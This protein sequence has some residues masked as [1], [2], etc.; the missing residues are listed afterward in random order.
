MTEHPFLVQYN[1]NSIRERPAFLQWVSAECPSVVAIQESLENDRIPGRFEWPNGY[2][3]IRK[4]TRY[5]ANGRPLGG[6]VLLVR[7]ESMM[8]E[9]STDGPF[10]AVAARVKIGKRQVTVCSLYWEHGGTV[11]E[12][13]VVAF[14]GSLPQPY[15]VMADVNAKSTSWGSGET[16]ARGMILEGALMSLTSVILNDGNHTRLSPQT[17]HTT[18]PDVTLV[19]NSLALDVDWYVWGDNFGS[20]HFPIVMP[21]LGRGW[22]DTRVTGETVECE[23]RYDWER[24]DWAEY[25]AITGEESGLREIRNMNQL[26]EFVKTCTSQTVPKRSFKMGYETPTPWWSRGLHALR[27]KSRSAARRFRRNNSQENGILYRKTRAIFRRAIKE[28][29]QEHWKRV[30]EDLNFRSNISETWEKLRRIQGKSKPRNRK[31]TLE[32]AGEI[33]DDPEM[34]A[35]ILARKFAEVSSTDPPQITQEPQIEED[36]SHNDPFSFRELEN[37]MR[38]MNK[39]SAPGPDGILY[40]QIKE[41]NQ[42]LLNK[43]LDLF[44]EIWRTGEQ[45]HE[46]KTSIITPVLKP[47][48]DATDPGNYRPIALTSMLARIME[49]M[50]LNR[51]DWIVEKKTCNRQYGFRKHIN[52]EDVI[53]EVS[54]QAQTAKFLCEHTVV[55]CL[56][57]KS[58]YDYTP[59]QLFLNRLTSFGIGGRLWKF[60]DSS[61]TDRRTQVKVQDRRSSY[62]ELKRG[63][64]QGSILSPTL[65]RLALD[66]LFECELLDVKILAYAD[67]ITLISRK[68]GYHDATGC[69]QRTL[70]NVERWMGTNGFGLSADKTKLIHFRDGRSGGEAYVDMKG[71][72]MRKIGVGESSHVN[73][74]GVIF[75]H[76]LNFAEHVRRLGVRIGT[77]LNLMRALL[78]NGFGASQDVLRR[79][80]VATVLPILDYGSIAFNSAPQATLRQL[81][82]IQN[83]A[84]RLISGALKSTPISAM[85]HELAL[86]PLQT[87]RNRI[88][89]SKMIKDKALGNLIPTFRGDIV[90]IE[91]KMGR[92]RNPLRPWHQ[93]SRQLANNTDY[94]FL[95]CSVATL[96]P[97]DHFPWTRRTPDVDLELSGMPKEQTIAVAY[98]KEF[99]RIVGTRYQDRRIIYTDGSRTVSSGNQ[100]NTPHTNSLITVGFAAV[101]PNV[102]T[103]SGRL[104]PQSSIASAELRAIQA[105]LEIASEMTDDTLIAS[106]SLSMLLKIQ[107]TQYTTD[108]ALD[109]LLD[110]LN[111]IQDNNRAVTLIW[112]PSHVGIAGNEMADNL[113]KTTAP[114]IALQDQPVRSNDLKNEMKRITT[115][116]LLEQWS[117]IEWAGNVK[118]T[119][120]RKGYFEGWRRKDQVI[121]S[122]LRMRRT[123]VTHAYRLSPDGSWA[124]PQTQCDCGAVRTVEHM[125]FDCPT[126]DTARR[127]WKVAPQQL[128]SSENEA[129]RLIEFLRET[130]LYSHI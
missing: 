78:G 2:E 118:S 91:Q 93:V 90:R 130:G 63:L 7:E 72:G 16:C 8:R 92:L 39:D 123:N 36:G 65:F 20:D 43:L 52:A 73:I 22:V 64:Q 113:A 50:V 11:T 66:R 77:R 71:Q 49:R 26:V 102:A 60:I 99:N 98:R 103:R 106:D 42:A 32:Q 125:L 120:A 33:V 15:I 100:S 109:N 12:E 9:I 28:A 111:S 5:S 76:G 69:L 59:K 40:D 44:N 25:H 19:S 53:A 10:D 21:L 105:A 129:R 107:N 83:N 94:N 41:A 54:K 47:G 110:T 45:P 27:N 6:S 24:A 70:E 95:R 38:E 85:M 80:Y 88:I 17:G 114:D 82:T 34:V 51:L 62:M 74:L 4:P 119:M 37:A 108:L 89:M 31:I 14:L 97:S 84:M 127:I 126:T 86:L 124:P 104:P 30:V 55:L 81:D 48:R 57:L 79:I 29:I 67:D 1:A 117:C 13:D 115:N 35:E 128:R 87:R 61:T 58:A 121:M 112:I 18:C 46:W 116:E 75:D 3:V 56:D 68:K 101:C 122:R 23:P 96:T